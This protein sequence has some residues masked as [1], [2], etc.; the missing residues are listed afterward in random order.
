MFEEE[1]K[2]GI[3][4][5]SKDGNIEGYFNGARL[6]SA[7]KYRGKTIIELANDIGVSKQAIS[8]YENGAI[9]PVFETLIKI[10]DVLKFPREYFYERD[11]VE[12]ELGNTYFRASSKM[13]KKEENIQKEKSKLVGKLFNFLNEYIEFPE[14]DL[15][16]IDQ[17]LS[18][19][20][21]AMKIR[22]YW[23]LGEEPIDDIIYVLEKNGIIVTSMT[24][25]SQNVDAYTQRQDI[26]GKK[27]FI[28]VLGNDKG[29]AARRQFS[30]AH[31]LGHIIMHDAFVE[32]D[33]LT[34]EEL[35][36]MEN[37]AHEF[38]ATL[39]LP[40]NAFAKDVSAYPTNLNY[41][42]QLKK[43]WKTSISAML[44]RANHLNILTYSS[45]QS[46]MKKISKLGWRKE[47]PLDDTLIM[48]KPTVL[49]RA[50]NILIDNDILSEEDFLKE[51][52]KRGLSL[53]AEEIEMLLG[54]DKGKLSIRK[55]ESKVIE[56]TIRKI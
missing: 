3:K 6:K 26:N 32:I 17:E 47:E 13:T 22:E 39:L 1:K 50:V 56:M 21:I 52:S 20:E 42:T 48:S 31:E 33:D 25:D 23:N 53:F 40:K 7:R 11:S 30:A 29:S 41:Y 35:R 45:Y 55:K 18:V 43:K 9:Y 2:E 5:I 14:L 24:T 38:A 12:V 28:I 36:N 44:V 51:L 49:K 34:N 4:K 46:I 54:L 19:E 15:P 10:I 27:H 16:H 37:Q 8:Q